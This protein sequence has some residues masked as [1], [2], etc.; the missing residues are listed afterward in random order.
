MGTCVPSRQH[1]TAQRSTEHSTAQ[2]TAQHRT[3]HSTAQR[4]TQHQHNISTAHSA[5]TALSQH[6]TDHS[7]AQHRA[8]HSTQHQHSTAHSTKPQRSTVQLSTKTQGK[9]ETTAGN[10]RFIEGNKRTRRR[11]KGREERRGEEKDAHECACACACVCVYA[12]MSVRACVDA[13]EQMRTLHWRSREWLHGRA[14]K[15]DP[16]STT[17]SPPAWPLVLL[18]AVRRTVRQSASHRTPQCPRRRHAHTHTLSLVL[19]SLF[20]YLSVCAQVGLMNMGVTDPKV[21]TKRG[22]SLGATSGVTGIM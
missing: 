14:C 13:P 16:S 8:Q 12:C 1:S 17:H 3:A 11:E 6:S 10:A 19:F 2:H 15:S 4:S 20:C 9:T 18:S 5:S 22:T 7:T 21:K